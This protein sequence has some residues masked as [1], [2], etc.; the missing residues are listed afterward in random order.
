VPSTFTRGRWE[1]RDFEDKHEVEKEI[2]EFEKP[3]STSNDSALTTMG[4]NLPDDNV[5]TGA[6][7]F[8]VGE[9]KESSTILVTSVVSS[10]AQKI[11]PTNVIFSV[12]QFTT[13]DNCCH[14]PEIC[15]FEHDKIRLCLKLKLS[16]I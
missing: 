10:H 14:P 5:S 12:A 7:T 8:T 4:V 6:A 9:T 1:C 16:M 3:E 13:T 11:A 15:E 2:L